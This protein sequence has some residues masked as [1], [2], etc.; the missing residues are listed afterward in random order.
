MTPTVTATDFGGTYTGSTYPATATVT[1]VSGTA[2][3][4]LEGVGLLLMYYA[5]S[6]ASGSG[7]LT[8]P[9]ARARIP[10]VAMFAGSTDYTSAS[11]SD[12]LYDYR[13]ARRSITVSDSRGNVQRLDLRG[14]GTT[15]TG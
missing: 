4:S 8:A 5:G 15:V 1:G 13:G 9:S 11:S 2:A 14:R 12:D 10:S 7:A 6:T 3:T